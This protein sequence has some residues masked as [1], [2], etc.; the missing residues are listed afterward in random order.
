MKGQIFRQDDI[1]TSAQKNEDVK[2][3]RI[4]PKTRMLSELNAGTIFENSRHGAATFKMTW[5]APLAATGGN[6]SSFVIMK[7]HA[8]PMIL[9]PIQRS[10]KK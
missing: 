6:I 3:P 5:L 7:P 10:A 2:K 8:V 1:E 9:F 4:V